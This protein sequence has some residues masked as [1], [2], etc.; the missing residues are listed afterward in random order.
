MKLIVKLLLVLA[1]LALAG[2]T[3]FAY[4]TDL[5]PD[6]GTVTQPVILD[7]Q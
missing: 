7:G 5:A 3:G 1:V 6:Q 2:L 4:L